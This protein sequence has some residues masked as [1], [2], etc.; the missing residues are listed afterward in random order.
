MQK[1]KALLMPLTVYDSFGL[2]TFSL[3]KLNLPSDTN[4]LDCFIRLAPLNK[5]TTSFDI[6]G[7]NTSG[8]FGI[9]GNVTYMHRN[10]FRGAE[11]FQLSF[12]GGGLNGLNS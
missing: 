11:V 6:E 2:L 1:W 8:N 7:T 5:Q 3:R 9:A 12:L 10:L 4:L